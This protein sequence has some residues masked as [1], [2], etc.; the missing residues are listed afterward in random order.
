MKS[1]AFYVASRTPPV[2]ERRSAPLPWLRRIDSDL[3][4]RKR[5]LRKEAPPLSIK[6]VT[7]SAERD[8]I[9]LALKESG[10]NKSEAARRLGI[11]RTQ[12]YK[13]LRKYGLHTGSVG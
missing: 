4:Q 8:A 11:H 5:R 1:R 2:V 12:L 10:N 6:E 7:K 9:L 13:K 3:F